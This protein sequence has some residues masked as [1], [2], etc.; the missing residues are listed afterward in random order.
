MGGSQSLTSL[1]P[2]PQ[3]HL[4]YLVTGK[5]DPVTLFGHGLAGSIDTTRPFGSAVAGTRAYLHF[6]GHGA[7]S[8]PET[9]WTYRALAEEFGQVADKVGATQ[10]L[11]VSM[12]AGAICNLLSTSPG[13][14]DK[15]ILVLPAV[16]DRPREDAALSRL[17]SMAR[18]ADD[19]DLDA[20]TEQLL[21]EQPAEHRDERVV[22]VW[23]AQQAR[24]IATTDVS[25]ALRTI[26]HQFALSDRAALQ[27]VSA[28][29]RIIAQEADPAHPVWVARELA[30]SFPNS[31]LQILPPGGILWSHRA[32]VRQLVGEFL[33]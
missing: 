2:T 8:S 25:R 27:D 11:G 30:D 15:V 22:R 32:R 16:I 21:L 4:E 17:V 7:S 26:P 28:P 24:V 18:M 33:S 9:P 6:R 31:D 3:G 10:A 19:H 14:F 29:V 23:C 20:L 5:G 1:L 13:R 12:G